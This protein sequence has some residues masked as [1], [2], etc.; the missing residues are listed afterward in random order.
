M[1]R[2]KKATV[3]YFPHDT[4]HGSTMQ[5]L[6]SKWGND[7]Y[8]FWFKL[9]E[10][11]GS[12]D[13]HY[14]D[15][16][17]PAEWEF[18]T[19]KT[20]LGDE[21]AAA[22][23]DMLAKLD[24]IDPFLWAK[25]KVV[26]CPKFLTRIEDAYRKR[27]DSLPTIEKVYS[28]LNINF[29]EFPAEETPLNKVN[30]AGSTERER[31]RERESKEN[32]KHLSDYSDDFLKFWELYPSKTGKGAAWKSWKKQKPPIEKVKQ[33]LEWQI[34]SQKWQEGFIP[35]PTTYLNQRR[36]ED[37]NSPNLAIIRPKTHRDLEDERNMEERRKFLEWGLNGA[38]GL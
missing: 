12:H 22:I 19:A 11:L 23:L 20:H 29:E 21:T 14:I 6:E 30:D 7:G 36:W 33:A 24:A 32:L 35:N 16:R 15:C 38:N 5:V 8:A 2:P 3:D 34:N 25:H 37:E 26:F 31:E 18:L 13:G 4:C 28:A 1:A 27:K 9:L 17:K 10:H